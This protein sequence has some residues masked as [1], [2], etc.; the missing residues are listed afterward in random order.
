VPCTLLRV[1]PF[2]FHLSFLIVYCVTPRNILHASAWASVSNEVMN[3]PARLYMQNRIILV[4]SIN[5]E[6][7]G[8]SFVSVIHIQEVASAIRRNRFINES[9]QTSIGFFN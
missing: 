2:Y 8:F 4:N 7:I 9:I 1:V 5:K 3:E 6:S